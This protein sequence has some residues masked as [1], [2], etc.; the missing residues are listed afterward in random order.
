MEIAVESGN[1]VRAIADVARGWRRLRN[2]Y[3][4]S[5]E[6]RL[7]LPGD[8]LLRVQASIYAWPNIYGIRVRTFPPTFGQLTRPWGNC[9][10]HT[11]LLT[12]TLDL[13]AVRSA[14]LPK[15]GLPGIYEPPTELD[16]QGRVGF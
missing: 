9:L 13:A 16:K 12:I 11:E 3:G 1:L 8:E 6:C 5:E 2:T 15:S 14:R 10:I 4:F 7:E